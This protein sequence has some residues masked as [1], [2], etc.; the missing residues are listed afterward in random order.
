[1]PAEK[2]AGIITADAQVTTLQ[3]ILAAHGHSPED[4]LAGA[5]AARER[6][7]NASPQTTEGP[8]YV[9]GDG[10][11][12]QRKDIADGRPGVPLRL[13]ITVL[14]ADQGAPV[15]GAVVDVWHCDALGYYSGYLAHDPDTLP[16]MDETGHV[17]PSDVSRFLR[18]CQPTGAD[19]AAE[20]DTVYPGWY[21]TR[22]IHIHVKVLVDGQEVYTGQLYLPEKYNEAIEAFPPYNQHTT[23]E[24]LPNEDDLVY[25][26]VGGEDLLLDV[27]AVVP[28]HIQG[29][30]NASFTM[31]VA[32][33]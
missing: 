15:D 3:A 21:F 11:P 33:P 16:T 20:F 2:E 13:R 23:L 1:M 27:H 22:S 7:T 26:T 19:G 18:G 28:G 30:L 10:E 17:P 32:L 6:T 14:S 25:R 24:R 5:D 29:G 8:Y 9:P 12:L 4:V 31:T